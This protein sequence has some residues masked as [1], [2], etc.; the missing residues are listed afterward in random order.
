[1]GMRVLILLVVRMGLMFPK[2]LVG[3]QVIFSETLI[4]PMTV[5]ATVGAPLGLERGGFLAHLQ[6]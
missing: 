6:A 4:V 5:S 3:D 2:E 1:M